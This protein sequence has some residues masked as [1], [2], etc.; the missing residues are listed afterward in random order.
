MVDDL[1]ARA[2]RVASGI[3]SGEMFS[4]NLRVSYFTGVKRAS[5]QQFVRAGEGGVEVRADVGA[6]Q[7][8]QETGLTHHL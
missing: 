2:V 4:Q 8:L 3:L 7:F 5:P 1:D 6:A